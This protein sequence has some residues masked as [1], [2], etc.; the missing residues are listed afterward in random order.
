MHSLD[1]A[2]GSHSRFS[3]SEEDS[4]EGGWGV[5]LEGVVSG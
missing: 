4:L 2:A 3:I 5:G 1:V